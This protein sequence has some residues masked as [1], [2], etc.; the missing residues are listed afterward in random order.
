MQTDASFLSKHVRKEEFFKKGEIGKE[1]K[2]L[3]VSNTTFSN[4]DL[5]SRNASIGF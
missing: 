4:Y 3:L 2:L 1:T 5:N